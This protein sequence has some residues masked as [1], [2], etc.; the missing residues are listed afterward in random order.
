MKRNQAAWVSVRAV[1][2]AAAV[3]SMAAGAAGCGGGGGSAALKMLPSDTKVVVGVDLNKARGTGVWETGTDVLRSL[4]KD[5]TVGG[6]LDKVKE[7]LKDFE[8]K[9]GMDPVNDLTYVIFGFAEVK[10]DL[11]GAAIITSKTDLDE[12][13][14]FDFME[15][16]T[17]SDL[18]K[19]EVKGMKVYSDTK[20]NGSYCLFDKRTFVMGDH[21]WVDSMVE[22]KNGKGKS[23]GDNKELAAAMKK[24]EGGAAV[25]FAA[26]VDDDLQDELRDTPVKGLDDATDFTGAVTLTKG[27][28]A[29]LRIGFA[30]KEDAE[31]V[32][33]KLE[34]FAKGTKKMAKAMSEGMPFMKDLLE[35]YKIEAK[36]TDAVVTV[37]VG[38]ETVDDIA[39]WLKKDGKSF[40]PAM[41]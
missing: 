5:D 12:D 17:G 1:A 9:T 13:A 37:D 33:G 30:K 26:G 31:D 24:V 15:E 27:I 8:K 35:A 29:A 3:A 7:T 39:K 6:S 32:A 23:A 40:L 18:D 25:W 22:L 16:E 41:L 2:A 10:G 38:E 21:D 28:K 4:A 36:G 34:D 14:I 19:D 11:Q 20:G